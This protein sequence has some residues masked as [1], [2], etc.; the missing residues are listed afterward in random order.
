MK[1]YI[2]ALLNE[3]SCEYI[4]PIQKT[5]SKK[6]KANRNLPVPHITLEVI[7]NPNIDKITPIIEKVLKV[8]KYFKVETD[9][10]IFISDEFRT[11]NVL[12]Q[13]RGYIKK[14]KSSFDDILKLH[15]FNLRE[16]KDTRLSLTLANLNYYQKDTRRK[17][18]DTNSLSQSINLSNC[19]FKVSGFEIWK[20]P[21]N[22]RE[23]KVKRFDLKTF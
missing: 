1:Y 2:V 15:G 9:D 18:F 17:G 19:T 23:I 10:N 7:E 22:K 12:L 13:Q 14:I 20:V 16:I 11:V 5:V 3:D 4:N 21:H 6:L 8:Y